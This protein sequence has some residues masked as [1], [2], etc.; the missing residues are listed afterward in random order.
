MCR[1]GTPVDER[2]RSYQLTRSDRDFEQI[3]DY[4]DD[5]RDY[6]FAKVQELLDRD[7]FEREFYNK[8]HQ[9]VE[10]YNE[11]KAITLCRLRGWSLKQKFNRWFYRAL[12]N[13]ASNVRASKFRGKNIPSVV[14]PVC[15]REVSRIDER[16]LQHLRT[17]QDLPSVFE[18]GGRVYRTMLKPRKFARYYECSLRNAL[19]RLPD[20]SKKTSW[21]WYLHDG[22]TPGVLCPLT[23]DIVPEITNEYIQA[24]PA[25]HRHYAPPCTW[26]EFQQA[27]PSALPHAEVYSLEYGGDGEAMFRDFVHVNA[28]LTAAEIPP[29]SCFYEDLK[30]A[31][32]PIEYEFV[33]DAI[34]RYVV[35]PLEREILKLA[36]LGYTEAEMCYRLCIRKAELNAKLRS[37][38]QN[39][40]L[41]LALMQK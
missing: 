38:R 33:V 22:K 30:K 6:W 27:H 15:M 8:L 29:Y 32:V 19:R 35:D 41:H 16:H 28:R 34:R 25:E 21:P 20:R 36:T 3:K 4:Y 37:L 24:M 1:D 9:A 23:G 11:E 14:C 17:V 13:W 5:F 2:V 31:S 12:Q 39:E 7:D 18:Y 40:G 10:T 26:D